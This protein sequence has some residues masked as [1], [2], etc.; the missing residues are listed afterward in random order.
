MLI[1]ELNL[2]WLGTYRSSQVKRKHGTN[3]IWNQMNKALQSS[4]WIFVQIFF[5]SQGPF[6]WV[7]LMPKIRDRGDTWET[8]LTKPSRYKNIN[9][10]F[11]KSEKHKNSFFNVCCVLAFYVCL[12]CSV[13]WFLCVPFCQ[14][15]LKLDISTL[16]STFFLWTFLQFL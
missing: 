9:N 16:F 12:C 5:R 10:F 7:T 11:F 8:S 13:C 6:T 4:T 15:S 2:T 3:N 1:K 14:G